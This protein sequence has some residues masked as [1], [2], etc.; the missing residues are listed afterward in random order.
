MDSGLQLLATMFGT[1]FPSGVIGPGASATISVI[2]GVSHQVIAS[3]AEPCCPTRLAVDATAN[4]VYALKGIGFSVLVIDG[5]TNTVLTSFPS[6]H[7]P[8][9]V[10]VDPLSTVSQPLSG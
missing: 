4:R 3:I 8:N 9:E 2:D 6:G 5:A 10:A 7:F 1:R